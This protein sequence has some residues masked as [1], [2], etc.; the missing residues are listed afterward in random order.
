MQGPSLEWR[1]VCAYR[2]S[3]L[4]VKRDFVWDVGSGLGGGG[5]GI[6]D[7]LTVMREEDG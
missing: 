5:Q 1:R 2:D 6:S 7:F 4:W 3:V